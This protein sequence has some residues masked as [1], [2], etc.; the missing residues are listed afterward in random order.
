MSQSFALQAELDQI[1]SRCLTPQTSSWQEEVPGRLTSAAVL[2]PLVVNE[3]GIQVILTV[4]ARQLRHHSGQVSLPGGRREAADPDPTATAL[5]E[6]EEEIGLDRQA[7]KVV[8]GLKTL[9]TG[10]G[11]LINPIVGLTRGPF[12]PRAVEPEVAAVFEVPLAFLMDPANR[13]R[14]HGI[15]NGR[16]REYFEIPFRTHRIW[17]ATAAVLVDLCDRI[18][19]HAG[20]LSEVK[21]LTPEIANFRKMVHDHRLKVARPWGPQ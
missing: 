5:R 20:D 14:R 3:S 11:F 1:L 18:V 6:C 10:T 16:L 8:G 13:H 7:V 21:Q 4:R 12:S 15:H 2:V 19:N 9:E 17:G